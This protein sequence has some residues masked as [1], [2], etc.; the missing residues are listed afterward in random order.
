[1]TEFSRAANGYQDR[2]LFRSKQLSC[3]VPKTRGV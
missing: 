3:D 1:M 2:L